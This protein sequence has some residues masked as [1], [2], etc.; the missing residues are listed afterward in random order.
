[1]VKDQ[2]CVT[3]D[4]SSYNTHFSSFDWGREKKLPWQNGYKGLFSAAR[5]PHPPPP[6]LQFQTKRIHLDQLCRTKTKLCGVTHHTGLFLLPC[7][8]TQPPNTELP[9]GLLLQQPLKQK[10]GYS[11]HWHRG[12]KVFCFFTL[13]GQNWNLV[14]DHRPEQTP[15]VFFC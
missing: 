1:M 12:G 6:P 9:T 10:E 13:E 5:D 2:Y 7:T 15:K 14:V 3:N 4:H 8:Y 11:T